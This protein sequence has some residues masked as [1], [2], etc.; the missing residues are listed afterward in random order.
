MVKME[1]NHNIYYKS[2]IVKELYSYT[3]IILNRQDCRNAL[4]L[5]D[6][7]VMELNSALD[8]AENAS[9]VR[10]VVITGAGERP[11]VQEEI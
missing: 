6:T 2:I 1:N 9:N 5:D 7:T 4:A 8:L 10:V 11:L 3:L